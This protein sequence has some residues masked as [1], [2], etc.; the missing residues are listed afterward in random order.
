MLFDLYKHLIWC[1][2]NER[3]TAKQQCIGMGALSRPAITMYSPPSAP[4][5]ETVIWLHRKCVLQNFPWQIQARPYIYLGQI[6]VHL[7]D[8]DCFKNKPFRTGNFHCM[9]NFVKCPGLIVWTTLERIWKTRNLWM[10]CCNTISYL[11]SEY[12]RVWH[13]FEKVSYTFLGYCIPCIMYI[14]T[15]LIHICRIM[16]L[17]VNMTSHIILN[18]FNCVHIR[19]YCGP[20]HYLGT[21]LVKNIHHS[22][23]FVWGCIILN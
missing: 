16:I 21:S 23:R 11:M 7:E 4:T 22:L 19:R 20:T 10:A 15:R 8:I 17:V 2:S 18:L 13:A 12:D 5:L 9:P 6:R 14:D 1:M 3:V